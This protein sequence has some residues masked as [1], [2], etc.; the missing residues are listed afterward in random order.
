MER[1]LRPRR[2]VARGAGDAP[3]GGPWPARLERRRV[4][5]RR[6]L[7]DRAS[8]HNVY[9]DAEHLRQLVNAVGATDGPIQPAWTFGVGVAGEARPAGTT[10]TVIYPYETITYRYVAATNTYRR[11]IDGATEP[12]IDAADGRVVTPANVV[13]LRMRFGA[14]NDGHPEKHR[15]DAEDV[16]SGE[17]IVSTN[18]RIV[19]GT[20]SKASI[21]G[22]T[23]LFGPDGEPVTLTAGQTFVQVIA[24]SYPF[25]VKEGTIPRDEI[26]AR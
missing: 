9:S 19:V 15:L 18:G 1:G 7:T 6:H 2:R 3:L 20:W 26:R 21:S 22:A 16:G 23:L 4:P 24:L 25:E 5:L 14:L 11:Y 10:L 8:P 12:Q 13:I 17:A